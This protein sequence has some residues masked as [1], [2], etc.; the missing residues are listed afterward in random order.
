MSFVDTDN[1]LFAE[2][3]DNVMKQLCVTAHS[4]AILVVTKDRNDITARDGILHL[5]GEC[6][7]RGAEPARSTTQECDVLGVPNSGERRVRVLCS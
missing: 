4:G 1:I 6:F 2:N 5:Y 3:D 7:W